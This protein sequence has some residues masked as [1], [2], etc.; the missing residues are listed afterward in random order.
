VTSSANRG[1]TERGRLVRSGFVDPQRATDALMLLWD[2][3]FFAGKDE[4]TQEADEALWIEALSEAADPDLALAGLVELAAVSAPSSAPELSGRPAWADDDSIRPRLIAVLG[5]SQALAQHLARHP[6]QVADLVGS[7]TELPAGERRTLMVQAVGGNAESADP[8]AGADHGLTMDALRVEYRRQLLQIAA[9][10]LC[11]GASM[12]WVSEQL[13]D[14][15]AAALEGGLAIA[16]AQVDGAERCRL[17]VIGMGKCGG[18]ELNYISDVDVIFVAEPV[19][20]V[21][22]QDA[23]AIGARL[24]GALIHACGDATPEGSLWEVDA[25]LRPEGKSGALVRTLRSHVAY[26]EKWASTWEFQ[27]LLKARP[28]AGDQALGDAYIEAM[29]PMVWAAASRKDFVVDVQAMRRRVE[30]NIPAKDAGRQLKLGPGGLRDVEFSV[31][32]LQLVHGRDDFRLR[33]ATTLD[34]LEAL[35]THGFVGRDDAAEL[36]RAYRFLRTMEHR[37]QLVRLRR[38][39]IVP[40]DD[41]ELRRLGRS[42]GFRTDPVQELLKAWRG[43][44]REVRRLHEKLFYRPLLDAVA[45]LE[46]GQARLTLKAA[47]ARLEALGFA[48]PA[49]ALRHIEALTSGISRRATVQKALLPVMLSWF[50][51]SP[52]PDAGLLAFRQVSDALGSTPWYLRLLRDEGAAAE[53]MARVLGSSGYAADLLLRAPEATSMFGDQDDLAPRSMT[54]LVTEATTTVRRQVDSDAAIATVRAIRRRELLRISISDV[55]GFVDVDTVCQSVSVVARAVVESGLDAAIRE[56]ERRRGSPIPTRFAVIAMG[57][58]GGRELGYGS[59][60]D[61]LFVHD[62]LAGADETEAAD[63]ALAVANELTRLLALPAPDPPLLIDADLRPEGR[64]GPLV[65][66]LASY[67]AYYARWSLVWE[68][69]ALLRAEPVAGDADL[70]HA[71]I[72]LIDP[73]RYPAGGLSADDTREVRRIKARVE[74]ERLPRGA[75]PKMHTKL[76]PGGLADVEWTL[77]LLQLQHGHAMTDLRTTSTTQG[78]VAARQAGLISASDAE[79]LLTAWRTATAIRNAVMLSKGRA[80]DSIPTQALDR[81]RLS[82]LLGYDDARGRLGRSGDLVE[83]YLRVTRRARVVVERVFYG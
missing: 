5:A 40:D 71:F 75:D 65:R 58:F 61:V 35:S 41:V 2:R 6:E 47:Q 9:A 43:H 29:A 13:A 49:G 64:Q 15:A 48:D 22:E 83:D 12:P 69:Q 33:S 67:A 3:G 23:M 19:E 62:P 46:P 70:G 16:R 74:N 21:D 17:A 52:D 45:R 55:L 51:D 25:A 54:A 57:R 44:Q 39:H 60:A 10:D 38:T 28:I 50:A 59:D 24:A 73:V 30:Q 63:S 37:I 72:E 42:M 56:V 7:L 66:S 26:Y 79:V 20:G 27:A 76:G 82:R 80:A 68:S 18:R 34:A 36:D 78:L 11:G 32:L 31:Q 4:A 81:A 77:Q 14:L 8:I 53:R 1:S